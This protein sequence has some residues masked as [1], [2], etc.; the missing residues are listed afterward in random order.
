MN[1]SHAIVIFDGVCNLCS[2]SVQFIIKRDKPGFFQFISRQS[3]RAKEILKEHNIETEPE[4]VV[5]ILDNKTYQKSRAALVICS[6]LT[7]PWK[8]VSWLRIIPSI[9]LDP[10]YNLIAKF[11]Y[12]IW[13]KK[14]SCM[15]P[16][17]EIKNRFLD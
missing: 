17:P 15:I 12:K 10:F 14:E 7:W 4:S 16:S 8:I 2:N 1:E 5:L 9:L 6:R 13:G 11:R 3:T